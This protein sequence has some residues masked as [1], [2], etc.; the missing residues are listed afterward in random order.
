LADVIQEQINHGQYVAIRDL[1]YSRAGITLGDSKQALVQARLAK[2]LRVLG[3]SNYDEYMDV[4][5]G[6]GADEEIVHLLDAISTNFT[7]FY[8]DEKHFELLTEIVKTAVADGKGRFRLWCAAAATGEEPYTLSMVCQEAAGADLKDLRILATDISTRALESCL[9]G[10]YDEQKLAS[11]PESLKRK[12]WNFEEGSY[13]AKQALRAP[14]SF[15]RLNLVEAPYPMGGPMDAIFCRN[16]M[17]YF[18]REGRSRFV[19]EA[20]RLLAPGG[21]L[22][23]GS[24]ESLSGISEGMRTEMPSVYRKGKP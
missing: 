2:R 8:R 14:L 21:Y 9:R 3:L 18:D 6:Q 5:A 4:L 13:T 16:V 20:M 11:V 22:F 24:S 1:V 10:S 12:W 15:A 19:R 23:V 7:S 17:I